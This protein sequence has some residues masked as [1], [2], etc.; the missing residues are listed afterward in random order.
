MGRLGTGFLV[1]AISG[2][3]LAATVDALRDVGGPSSRSAAT[4]E[5]AER[6]RAASRQ[7]LSEAA[8]AELRA[9]GVTGTLVWSDRDCVVRELA[10]PTLRRS[11]GSGRGCSFNLSPGGRVG[12]DDQVPSPDDA[13]VARCSRGRVELVVRSTEL[14]RA[15]VRGCAPAWRPDGVLTFVRAGAVVRLSECGRPRPCLDVLVPR[16]ELDRSLTRDPWA[17]RRPAFREV[18]KL[19][20]LHTRALAA[21]SA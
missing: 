18:R 19:R 1:L 12:V 20:D 15:R 13:F 6:A 3:A 2:L 8:A 4:G 14:V 10:V 17:L 11:A 9:Q 7:V 5:T 21:A 16:E